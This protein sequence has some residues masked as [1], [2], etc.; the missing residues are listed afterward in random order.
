MFLNDS[1]VSETQIYCFFMSLLF[2]GTSVY[3]YVSNTTFQVKWVVILITSV[4]YF[5]SGKLSKWIVPKILYI[6]FFVIFYI[7]SVFF[8]ADY[9]YIT[10]N[11][12]VSV[13]L[14]LLFLA[15]FIV[16]L[17]CSKFKI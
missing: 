10:I 8:K 15:L 3:I 9:F 12:T 5:Y 2:L 14:T 13:L 11:L 6:L 16:S 1:K 7:L 17:F 4:L